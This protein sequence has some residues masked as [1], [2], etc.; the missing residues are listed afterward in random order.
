VLVP[1]D[2][3]GRPE[4]VDVGQDV[5]E[6]QGKPGRHQEETLQGAGRR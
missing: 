2:A 6:V 3:Q 4:K 1:T 5:R